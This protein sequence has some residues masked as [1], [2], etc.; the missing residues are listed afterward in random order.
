MIELIEFSITPFEGKYRY[1]FKYTYNKEENQLNFISSYFDEN[2]WSLYFK[3]KEYHN[4][5]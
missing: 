3:A 5:L 2:I 4:E 1:I